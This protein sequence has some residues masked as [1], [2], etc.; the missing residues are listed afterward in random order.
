METLKIKD[1]LHFSEKQELA[2]DRTR[3]HKYV[4]YGGSM[5]SGKSHWLRWTSVYWLLKL[6]AETG[7]KGIRSGLFCEDYPSLHDRHITKIRT[8]FPSWLGDYYE[9]RHEFV[10]KPEYGSGTLALRNLDDPARY[11]SVEFAT[12]AVDE[13]PKNPLPTFQMLRTRLR[14]PGVKTPKF[15]AAC[16][17][18][19]EIWVKRFFVDRIFPPNEREKDQFT[20]VP[21]LPSD[22]PHLPEEYYAQL[23]SMP[24]RE[25]KA[26]L[27]G[28]WS[29][30]ERETDEWGYVNLI[31][32]GEV[33]NAQDE[34][35]NHYGDKILGVDPGGGGDETCIVL[36][37]ETAQ[38]IVF[39]QKTPDTTVIPSICAAMVKDDPEIRKIVVDVS[40][41][42]KG[43]YDRMRELKLPVV[44]CNFGSRST[45]KDRYENLKAELYWKQREWVLKAGGRLRRHD[46]WNEYNV[47][48]YKT[49]NGRIRIQSKEELLSKGIASPNVVDAAVLTQAVSRGMLDYEATRR[50][51]VFRDMNQEIWAQ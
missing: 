16:N 19:G 4:L 38:E 47:I 50:V 1:L 34:R 11:M 48:R 30:F 31:T 21:A 43:I 46:G 37:S 25:R 10:L 32:D 3:N 14:W 24:E 36:K 35:V 9:T 2:L 29:A 12:I 17:P 23:E 22:N 26:F 5:G 18:V 49:A 28:D 33:Q 27:E 51:S 42:G 40:G 6:H 41:I 44:E 20:F 7:L 39:K 8:E 13:L 45:N 15:F